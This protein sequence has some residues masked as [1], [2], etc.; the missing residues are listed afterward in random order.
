MIRWPILIRRIHLWAGL[1]LGL[2][3]LAW[4]SGGVVMTILPIEQVRG[5]HM[6]AEPPEPA[7]LKAAGP[8]LELEQVFRRYPGTTG[9]QLQWLLGRPVYLLQGAEARLIDARSG[10]RLDPLPEDSALALARQ[11][12][13]DPDPP[14]RARL[15]ESDPPGEIRDRP[16]PVWQVE[17]DDG[18]GTRLYFSPDNGRLLARRNDDWRLFDF[19]WMLHIMDY[20]ERSDFN[21]P[22]LISFALSAMLFTLSGFWLLWIRFR[23]RASARG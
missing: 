14:M 21:H 19:F 9:L 10:Q 5:E 6:A 1:F 22:L 7:P 13:R 18:L 16:L 17:V 20:D 4:T 8:L 2:Q 3:L 15:I 23:P 11:D 12:Y